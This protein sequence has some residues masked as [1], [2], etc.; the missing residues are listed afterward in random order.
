MSTPTVIYAHK[1]SW[2]LCQLWL[3]FSSSDRNKLLH[4]TAASWFF[5]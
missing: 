2:Q 1:A 4:S 3:Y 5:F